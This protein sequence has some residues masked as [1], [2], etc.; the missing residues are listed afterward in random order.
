MKSTAGGA[1]GMGKGVAPDQ[2]LNLLYGQVGGWLPLGSHALHRLYVG[3]FFVVDE[4][5]FR[6]H[7]LGT[8]FVNL[9]SVRAAVGVFNLGISG[10]GTRFQCL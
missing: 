7:G 10:L 1:R 3:L 9:T 8:R 4:R 5:G 2:V 6:I